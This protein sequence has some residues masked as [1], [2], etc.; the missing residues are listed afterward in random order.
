MS[1]INQRSKIQEGTK[2]DDA[3]VGGKLGIAG[4]G[5]REGRMVGGWLDKFVGGEAGRQLGAAGSF[6]EGLR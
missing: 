4:D 5:P 6:R 2:L 1:T 3:V